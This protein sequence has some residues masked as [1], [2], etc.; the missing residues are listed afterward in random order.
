MRTLFLASRQLPLA[1]FPCSLFE[2]VLPRKE[3]RAS[4]LVSLLLRT[5]ILLNQGL[6]LMISSNLNY[7]IKTLQIQM[8]I[9]LQ[10]VNFRGDSDI[11]SI[12]KPVYSNKL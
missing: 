2:C 9:G 3:E 10:Q 11:Q 4:C 8:N 12:T 6:M 1:M 7:L 5:L